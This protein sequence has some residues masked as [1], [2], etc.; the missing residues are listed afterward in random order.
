MTPATDDRAVPAH[1]R[2]LAARLSVLF[3]RDVEIVKQLNQA[4]DR[5]AHANEQL[6]TTPIIDT[7]QQIHWQIHRAFCAYRNAY[8]Q[9]RQLAVEVGEISQQFTDALCAAG[10]SAQQARQANVH[11]LTEP[12]P[13]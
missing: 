6:Y 10:Y 4:H 12:A 2:Q 11:Q 13:P 1:A 7:P 5:L 9:R 3:D 8:E